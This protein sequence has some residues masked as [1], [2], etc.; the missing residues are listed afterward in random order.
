MAKK[1]G[2]GGEPQEYD[3]STGQY[4]GGRTFR[5]NTPHHVI[6]RVLEK[7]EKPR[8]VRIPLDFFSENGIYRQSKAQ[9]VK[10]IKSKRERIVEHEGYI[11]N[12]YS[13]Y[14]DW[15]TFDEE[16]KRREIAHWEKEIRTHR[17][18]IADREKRI[19]ELEADEK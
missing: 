8:M 2:A 10:G 5:Q 6:S 14:I 1:T 9:L 3:T 19:K 17:R 12:P 13:K 15:D 7:H 18:E 11:K 4:G 16:R